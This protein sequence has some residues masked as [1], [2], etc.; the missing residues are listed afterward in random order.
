M[1]FRWTHSQRE[2]NTLPICEVTKKPIP[3]GAR[4]LVIEE[5]APRTFSRSE[6]KAIV[7]ANLREQGK[8]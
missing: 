1:T 2:N 8:V 7:L 3:H 4:M 5:L 6:G